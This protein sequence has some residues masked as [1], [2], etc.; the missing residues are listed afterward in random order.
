MRVGLLRCRGGLVSRSRS[1]TA[2]STALA[3][4]PGARNEQGR[5]GSLVTVNHAEEPC[6]EQDPRVQPQ[7]GT[8]RHAS[9]EC[10][11]QVINLINECGAQAMASRSP[12]GANSNSRGPGD[13]ARSAA[14]RRSR[15]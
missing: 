10:R 7:K 6:H 14:R 9:Y 1:G 15:G 13:R 12:S 3:A 8:L 4:K 11:Y 5:W 2:S